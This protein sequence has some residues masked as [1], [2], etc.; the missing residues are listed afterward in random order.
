MS[1]KLVLLF[2][3]SALS[4]AVDARIISYAPVTDQLAVP[5]VQHRTNRHYALIETSAGFSFMP[6]PF[7]P[8]YQNSQLVIYDSKGLEEPRVVLPKPGQSAYIATAAVWEGP[9]EV[10]HILAYSDAAISSDGLRSP[11]YI[12]SRDGG[13]TWINVLSSLYQPF[14]VHQTDVGGPIVRNRG[15]Q[16][17]IGNADYPF[18][19]MAGTADAVQIIAIAR[20]GTPKPLI[21]L[22]RTNSNTGALVGSNREGTEFLIVG[23]PLLSDRQLPDGLRVLDLNGGIR[24]VTDLPSG[25]PGFEGW[26]APDGTVYAESR[27]F[28]GPRALLMYRNGTRTEIASPLIG[29]ASETSFFAVPTHDYAGAWVVQRNQ[30]QPTILSRHTPATGLVEM[31]RDP[32]SPEVEAIHAAKSGE[33]LLVQVHRPRPQTDDRVFIDPA[34]AIWEIG[35]PAPAHY[36]ELFLNEG[37]LKAFV[38]LDVDAMAAGGTFVFD[39]ASTLGGGGAIPISP[40]PPTG[41]GGDVVQEWGVVRASLRQRLVIPSVARLPGAYGSFWLTDLVLYNPAAEPVSIATRY[42]PNGADEAHARLATVQLNAGEI[43]LI[44]DAAFALFGIENGS[45][46]LFLDPQDRAAIV[47]TSRTYTESAAGTFGMGMGAIDVNAAASARFAQYFSGA[48]QGADYRTNLVVTDTSG[49]G[50][51]V[52]LRATPTLSPAPEYAV[53]FGAP[54]GGQLQMNNVASWMAFPSAESGAL[55]FQPI[56][57]EG[58]GSVIAI[59]NRTNDPSYFPPDLPA[60]FGRVI[61]AIAHSEGVNGAQFR[62]DLFLFNPTEFDAPVALAAKR[63]D[64]AEAE[65]VVNLTLKK[66]EARVIRDVLFTLFGKTGVARLRYQSGFAGQQSGVRVTSRLYSLDPSGK[67]YGLV[68]P[69]LNSFQSASEGEGLEIVG[70]LGG[71]NFRTNLSLVDPRALT[72]NLQSSEVLVDIVGP[73]GQVLSDFQVLVPA[74][75]AFQINDIFRARNLGNGPDVAMFRV[76]VQKGRVASFATTLD[77]RTNDPIYL[78]PILAAQETP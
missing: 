41:G 20:D 14:V 75:G 11:R 72:P 59:D 63:W 29:A 74:G 38:H 33:R 43:R 9:D 48:L 71:P 69:P 58:I 13:A 56:R 57:G 27:G 28:G 18:V 46:A 17:R 3:A 78:P 73:D 19:F 68:M 39:S 36:D 22:G 54:V 66:G 25:N 76:R 49:R 7:A 77:N 32:A 67:T 60:Q 4:L 53:T 62:S 45:G 23:P 42:V 70:A 30:G 2:L 64:L 26:I 37:P 21:W 31:W 51:D 65:T 8:Y 10:P 34:L 55:I 24:D 16:F 15:S 12:Y 1:R 6:G 44:R 61:P 47:A 52:R 35:T 40:A 5:A 50:T